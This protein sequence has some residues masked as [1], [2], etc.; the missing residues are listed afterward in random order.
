MRFNLLVL[1]IAFA[2]PIVSCSAPPRG[3]APTGAVGGTSGISTIPPMGP[4]PA[5]SVTLV[6]A[7]DIASCESFGDEETAFL[8][9]QIP[10]TIFTTGDNVYS[11]G[12]YRE[13]EQC[14]NPSWGRHKSRTRPTPGNHDYDTPNGA[15]YYAYFGAAAG[16]RFKGYYSY[17]LGEWH[18]VAL[19][20]MIAHGAGSSQEK[21][22]TADLAANTKSC[23]L[24]YWHHP[25]FSS[26]LEHG[27]STSV[28]ALWNALYKANAELVINGHDH[29]YERFA[30]QTP[31]G[32]ADSVRGIREFVVGTG[33]RSHYHEGT[34]KAHSEIFESS[35]Y[36]VLRFTLSPGGYAWRFIPVS[37]ASFT[38]SGEGRCH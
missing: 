38:D 28:Q 5:G 9:D 16:D 18:I 24:A 19:N 26:G 2:M 4:Q 37:G 13:F 31:A 20:T 14:Y 1:L 17:D 12:S 10:G 35:T 32:A 3:P 34:L 21:W 29:S 22:L 6:G 8:L 27:N 33:G 7:G 30:P 23:T 15:G 25:R 11:S 36:G